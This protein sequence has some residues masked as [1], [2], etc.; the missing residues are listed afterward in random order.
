MSPAVPTELGQ[1]IQ[2][3]REAKGL[4]IRALGRIAHV[5]AAILSRLERGER[6][7]SSPEPLAR[8][9]HALDIDEQDLYALAGY[10]IPDGLPDF[11]P[12]LRAKYDLPPAA[13]DQLQ[14]YFKEV[15]DQYNEERGINDEELPN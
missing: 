15:D 6:M 12:Y 5:D 4:S 14:R 11:A 1:Y 10:R 7:V 8:I 2:K 9:A 13:I 3:R